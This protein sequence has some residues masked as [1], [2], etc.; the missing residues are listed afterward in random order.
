MFELSPPILHELGFAPAAEWLTEQVRE[1]H[2]LAA[3]FADDGL[4]KPLNEDARVLLFRAVQELLMNVVKHADAERVK[5]TLARVGDDI[6]VE[7]SDDGAGFDPDSVA[8][9]APSRGGFGLFS[10]R[11]RLGQIGGTL[12]I[13]AR[14]GQGTLS[15][16]V[17]PLNIETD[18]TTDS[19]D[20]P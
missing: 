15:T 8:P 1:Q 7:V 10:L 4:D 5:V 13:D 9:A 16:I 18:S 17:A 11:E 19:E 2:G 6:R 14:P 12:E 20:Q 3:F